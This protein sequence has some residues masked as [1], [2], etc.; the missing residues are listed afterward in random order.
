MHEFTGKYRGFRTMLR[1]AAYLQLLRGHAI[2]LSRSALQEFDYVYA[3]GARLSVG[4][5]NKERD[6]SLH[7][8]F[9]RGLRC[10]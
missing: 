1:H 2:S 8:F 7:L 10:S 9:T 6:I 3:L 4:Q 5:T